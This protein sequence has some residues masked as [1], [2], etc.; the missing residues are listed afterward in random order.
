VV[1]PDFAELARGFGARGYKIESPTDLSQIDEALREGSG[2]AIVDIRIN[3]D[4][5]LPVSWE[6]AKH[7]S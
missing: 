6:I 1:Q 2:P 3:G 4:F 7:L 5:E